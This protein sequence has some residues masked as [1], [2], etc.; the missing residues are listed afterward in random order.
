MIAC[1]MGRGGGGGGG[2]REEGREV[3]SGAVTLG[4]S[5]GILS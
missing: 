3:I 4:D 5:S 2:G 1:S